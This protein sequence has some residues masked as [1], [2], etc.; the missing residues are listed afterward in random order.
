[1]TWRAPGNEY[2]DDAWGG[3]KIGSLHLVETVSVF[4]PS[5]TIPPVP[6]EDGSS[7]SGPLA[8]Q[9]S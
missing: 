8:F 4:H 3:S 5:K 1:M 9:S 2:G 6:V 7:N